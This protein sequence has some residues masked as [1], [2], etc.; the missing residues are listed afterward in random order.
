VFQFRF[1]LADSVSSETADGRRYEAGVVATGFS[2]MIAARTK[3][4]RAEARS[5]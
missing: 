5:F 4:E 3:K 1:C 2:R